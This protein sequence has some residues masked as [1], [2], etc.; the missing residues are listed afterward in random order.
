M[1][2][3]SFTSN[4]LDKKSFRPEIQ[5]IR[6]IGALLVACFHIWG[7]AVSG[8]VDVFFVISG[9]FLG[10]TWLNQ[11][12]L[13][14]K[15]SALAHVNRFINRTI[16]EVT[17]VLIFCIFATLFLLSPTAWKE[18][19]SHI[20]FSA[21][22]LEN[23]WLII[24]STDYLAR[25]EDLSLVQHFWAISII[26]QVYV[27]WII[28]IWLANI[29]K[30]VTSKTTRF[31]VITILS[32][33][34]VFSLVWGIWF[35]GYKPDSAYFDPA[36]RYWQFA[37]G[38]LTALLSYKFNKSSSI[39]TAT[40]IAL[41]ISCGFIIGDSYKFPGLAAIWPVTGA[42]LIL[43]FSRNYQ[44][45]FT[46]ALSL[47]MVVKAGGLGFGIYLW[48]WPIYTLYLRTTN[49][50][51]DIFSGISI[52][53]L[54]F[55]LA[56]FS[57]KLA[58]KQKNVTLK[59][60]L[61]LISCLGF[62]AVT[63]F[64]FKKI[65]TSY[66]TVANTIVNKIYYSNIIPGP[67][68]SY[69][70]LPESYAL[71][72]HVSIEQSEVKTCIFNKNGKGGTIYL[73]GG[74]HAA[75]WLPALQELIIEKD[76]KI[77]T[78]TKSACTFADPNDS[79]LNERGFH[80]SCHKW[81][82]QVLADII[83][84]SPNAVIAV[85]TR[86]RKLDDKI[87]EIIPMAYQNNFKTLQNKGIKVLAIRDNPQM[88]INIPSCVHKRNYQENSCQQLRRDQLNDKEFMEYKT[89]VSNWLYIADPIKYFCNDTIC[90]AVKGNV[91]IFRDSH[92]LTVEYSKLLA[93]WMREQLELANIIKKTL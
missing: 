71:G 11:E 19:F 4:K 26:A 93:P 38:A 39:L 75:H 84:I 45:I 37:V 16:P 42:V 70:S 7:N 18:N 60:S 48:H 73:V 53:L 6:L 49:N 17:V 12:L 81:N 15:F 76:F 47:P 40:G 83:K 65:I 33:L 72:C 80:E 91:M 9:Y 88:D 66:P 50:D 69:S 55:I 31:C 61:I 35:T 20:F 77:Y 87:E 24:K 54:S 34:G 8:G 28:I 43:L 64:G 1:Q 3:S 52:I 41:L 36:S 85:G 46:K 59:R 2:D 13:G 58:S 25:N 22:Y 57:S 86:I 44:S 56:W 78:S 30:K 89:Q 51:P 90:K 63:S 5:G 68:A 67:L 14:K 92:H 62:I 32:I 29:L 74:S 27:S 23:F 10:F 82:Q 21:I 79:F